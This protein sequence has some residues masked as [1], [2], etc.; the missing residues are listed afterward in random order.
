MLETEHNPTANYTMYG[1]V[2]DM[3]FYY[4]LLKR[5]SVKKNEWSHLN[6]PNLGLVSSL[7]SEMCARCQ[8]TSAVDRKTEAISRT[9][10]SL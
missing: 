6:G 9:V 5:H 7:A 2:N 8:W 3:A 10:T 4:F 1:E